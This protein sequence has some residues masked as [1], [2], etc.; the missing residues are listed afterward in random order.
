LE[1]KRVTRGD[2]LVRQHLFAERC[3]APTGGDL[4]AILD[5]VMGRVAITGQCPS[6]RAR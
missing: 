6:Q 3:P 1:L 2:D 4:L 5:R